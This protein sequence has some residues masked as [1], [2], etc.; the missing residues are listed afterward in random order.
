[1]LYRTTI[2]LAVQCYMY[3]AFAIIEHPAPA[4]WCERH[5]SSW[6]LPMVR[7]LTHKL[8]II[9]QVYIDQC[10]LGAPSRK[11][12]VLGAVCIPQLRTCRDLLPHKCICPHKKHEKVLIGQAE[13]GTFLTAPAKTYPPH[14]CKL[15]A[16]AIVMRIHAVVPPAKPDLKVWHEDLTRFYQPLDPYIL[17]DLG[18][19][20]AMFNDSSV[21]DFE[22]YVR[23]AKSALSEVNIPHDLVQ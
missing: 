9:D 7:H 16:D 11:P 20:C 21:E 1:M 5:Q 23:A 19:D 6:R 13:D 14:M 17:R 15:I 8:E 12:T 18:M 4:V 10:T 2:L 3:G 22:F